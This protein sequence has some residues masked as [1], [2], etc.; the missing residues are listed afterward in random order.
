MLS[1]HAAKRAHGKLA[2]AVLRPAR[3]S[4]QNA[5]W[6]NHQRHQ[7]ARAVSTLSTVVN[8][9]RNT[10]LND[11]LVA[12]VALL[13]VTSTA[14]AVQCESS[15]SKSKSKSKPDSVEHFHLNPADVGK[16]NFEAVQA[17]HNVDTMPIYSSEQVAERNGED[18]KPIWM[19]YG[20]VVCK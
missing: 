9:D 12:A 14:T 1:F 16:E 15:K 6:P 5:S 7:A 8:D 17:S 2:A 20:G 19:S 4:F 10:H 13:A 18:G 11:V 3:N